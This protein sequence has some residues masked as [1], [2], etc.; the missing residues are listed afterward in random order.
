MVVG[1][2]ID[3]GDRDPCASYEKLLKDLSVIAETQ[4]YLDKRGSLTSEGR[5]YLISVI[6]YMAINRLRCIEAVRQ[7]LDRFSKI[8]SVYEC[9]QDALDSCRN[10]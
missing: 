1:I 2:R 4:R 3:G 7:L 6:R 8:E 5:A 10:G 9:I